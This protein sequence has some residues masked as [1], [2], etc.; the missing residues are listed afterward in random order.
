[1][2]AGAT[3]LRSHLGVETHSQIG[4]NKLKRCENALMFS[5]SERCKNNFND[6]QPHARKKISARAKT[7]RRYLGNQLFFP[8]EVIATAFIGHKKS[9]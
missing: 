1:L 5:G 8:A 9:D 2:Q 3:G 6:P 4:K 7:V